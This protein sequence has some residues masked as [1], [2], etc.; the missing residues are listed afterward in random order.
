MVV[1]FHILHSG[2]LKIDVH[3]PLSEKITVYFLL[4]DFFLKLENMMMITDMLEKC[5]SSMFLLHRNGL[6][7]LQ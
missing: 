7:G 2:H 5:L 3:M 4:S 1:F 6:E